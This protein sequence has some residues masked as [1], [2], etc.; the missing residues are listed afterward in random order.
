MSRKYR[1][2]MQLERGIIGDGDE[3]LDYLTRILEQTG[4]S[5]EEIDSFVRMCNRWQY[6]TE[7]K[8]EWVTWDEFYASTRN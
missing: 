6:A 2:L 5:D 4:E 8:P 7:A 3:S 1:V